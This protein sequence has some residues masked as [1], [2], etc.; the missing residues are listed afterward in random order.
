M[1]SQASI[2]HKQLCLYKTRGEKE[3]EKGQCLRDDII[4]SRLLHLPHCP[5]AGEGGG[6]GY[7]RLLDGRAR[8]KST[9]Y[10]Y[11][12]V[13]IRYA[14]SLLS[15]LPRPHALQNILIHLA[16]CCFP[17]T[18]TLCGRLDLGAPP[19]SNLFNKPLH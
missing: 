2:P 18:S 15:T 7:S 4:L 17:W 13:F 16:E 12:R 6:G 5:L 9:Q 19:P 8:R 14:V 11:V 1:F 10:L 3:G